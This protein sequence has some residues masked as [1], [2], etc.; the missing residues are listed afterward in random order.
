MEDGSDDVLKRAAATLDLVGSHL[1]HST[2]PSLFLRSPLTDFPLTAFLVH[3]VLPSFLTPQQIGID[4]GRL[5]PPLRRPW[6]LILNR[7]NLG[8][9]FL[10][11]GF[12]P[13]L[14]FKMID[15]NCYTGLS[16]KISGNL[17]SDPSRR[18]AY[19]RH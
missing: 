18:T 6:E 7:L 17:S 12:I 14:T 8:V 10:Y 19:L 2:L 4:F 9:N 15:S 16:G 5:H 3:S 13:F 11:F 1:L